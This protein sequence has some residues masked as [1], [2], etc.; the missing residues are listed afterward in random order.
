VKPSYGL[1]DD[2]VEAMI[3]E[4]FERAEEDFAARQTREAQVEADTI[5]LAL[6]KAQAATLGMPSASLNARPSPRSQEPAHALSHCCPPP[7]S[8]GNRE[9][10]RCFPQARRE[11][12]EYRRARRPQGFPKSIRQVAQLRPKWSWDRQERWHCR[13]VLLR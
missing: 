1:T 4:S 2:Q 12:D 6:D 13:F 3:T 5:L 11:H 10:R 9:T 7:D 8:R